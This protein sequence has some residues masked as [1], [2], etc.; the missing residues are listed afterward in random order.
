[1]ADE[2]GGA[3]SVLVDVSFETF[4]GGVQLTE[5]GKDF[6]GA[7]VVVRGDVILQFFHQL[8]RLIRVGGVAVFLYRLPFRPSVVRLLNRNC[9]YFR[10]LTDTILLVLDLITIYLLCYFT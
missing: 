7:G 3:G 6:V 5:A 2:G 4:V 10:F 1:M 8:L 9:S